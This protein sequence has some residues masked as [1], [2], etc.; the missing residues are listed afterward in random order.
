MPSDGGRDRRQAGR[1]L[2][3]AEH[4]GGVGDVLVGNE[5]VRQVQHA[6]FVG[7]RADRSR[8]FQQVRNAEIGEHAG[9]IDGKPQPAHT[10]NTASNTSGPVITRGDSWAWS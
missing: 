1:Q 4:F 3:R 7:E 2:D 6:G 9:A 5:Q 10:A 8:L